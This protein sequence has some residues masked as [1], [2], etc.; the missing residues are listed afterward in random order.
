[1]AIANQEVCVDAQQFD[2]RT[3]P[4]ATRQS[5]R[6]LHGLAAA[7]VAAVATLGPLSDSA[8]KK[9]KKKST[10]GP[11]GPE[12]PPGVSGPEGPPGI[13]GWERLSATT[14]SNGT[15]NKSLSLPCPAG[16]RLL[17]GG[18]KLG[19]SE[20]DANN[21]AVYENFAQSDTTWTVKGR[22]IEPA[23][24]WALEVHII[25]ANVSG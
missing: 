24:D 22:E 3:Q 8:A 6:G 23:D 25:C 13:S 16:K 1:M 9:K 14:G 19:V 7:A 20:Q 2:H 11:A 4:L 17:S 10:V 21:I 12:G 18:F 15:E 5:R